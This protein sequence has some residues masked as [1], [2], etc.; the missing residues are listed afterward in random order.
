MLSKYT[1]L[2]AVLCRVN[3]LVNMCEILWD[4]YP[5]CEATHGE[6]N[7]TDS[8][9]CGTIGQKR[10][11]GELA[12]LAVA[13]A[14]AN[15]QCKSGPIYGCTCERYS[16]A[17][18]EGCAIRFADIEHLAIH[19]YIVHKL[20]SKKQVDTALSAIVVKEYEEV[21]ITTSLDEE[22]LALLP[23]DLRICQGTLSSLSRRLVGP[24]VCSTPAVSR[25]CRV[26]ARGCCHG[27]FVL[28]P[29]DSTHKTSWRCERRSHFWHL[30]QSHISGDRSEKTSRRL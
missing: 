4:A 19:L 2:P 22:T 10:R 21:S 7:P 28:A 5:Q 1:D 14:M 13:N 29:H 30:T 15:K 3:M 20:T 17:K 25:P 11:A 18:A 27:W 26:L 9:L 12:I 23:K 24:A 16:D 6:K 8:G